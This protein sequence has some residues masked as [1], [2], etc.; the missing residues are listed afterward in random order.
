MAAFE[1]PTVND[2]LGQLHMQT[3]RAVAGF[4]KNKAQIDSMC[5]KAGTLQ[6]SRRV[7]QVL[8]AIDEH[9]EKGVAILLAELRRALQEPELD[10]LEL[11][12]LIGP[13]LEELTSRIVSAAALERISQPLQSGHVHELIAAR[14]EKVH[15][16]VRFWLRQFDIGWDEPVRPEILKPPPDLR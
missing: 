12:N 14:V 5:A 15:H 9:V 13:R 11:R 7:L 8:D 1:T 3:E 16:K 2:F 4:Q 10:P 6:S